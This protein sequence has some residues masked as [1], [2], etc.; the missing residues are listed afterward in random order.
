LAWGCCSKGLFDLRKARQALQWPTVQGVI[1]RSEI[2]MDK[3]SEGV[4][5][6]PV[7]EYAYT[8]QGCDYRSHSL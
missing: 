8:V 3:D 6:T 2:K 1:T 7:I 4:S 5:Y